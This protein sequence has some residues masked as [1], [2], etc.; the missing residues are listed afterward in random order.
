M[1]KIPIHLVTHDRPLLLEKVLIRLLKYTDWDKFELWIL[2][3]NSTIQNKKVISMFVMNNPHI[4]VFES[5]FNQIAYIQ[6]EL[7]K[8]TS[9]DIYIKLDD[10]IL[11]TVGWANAL[12]GV[13]QRNREKMCF[14]SLV[15]PI[16]GFGWIPFLDIMELREEFQK[17]FPSI[18]LRQDCMGVAVHDNDEVCR[19]IWQKCLEMD[20]IT[21]LF[22]QKQNNTYQDLICPHRYSIGAIIYSHSTWEK[23]GG[24]KVEEGFTK[25]KDIYNRLVTLLRSI[26]PTRYNTKFKSRILQILEI[27]L[28]LNKSAL[29]IEEEAIFQFSQKSGTG[30]YITTEGILFHFSFYPTEQYLL[31][32]IYS[33]INY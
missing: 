19:F 21:Q 8:Q 31:N 32:N 1:N 23:M 5:S 4:R 3:N 11:V 24:W 27:A 2:D 7:I 15:I 12:L 17:T 33:G 28:S 25:R 30:I 9:A 22:M 6:N 16:N 10:D 18:P 13:Y 20:D 26:S 29:G 14:G